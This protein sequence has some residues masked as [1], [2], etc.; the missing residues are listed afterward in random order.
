MKRLVLICLPFALTGCDKVIEKLRGSEAEAAAETMSLF[1][2]ELS[3]GEIDPFI[4]RPNQVVILDFGA[5]W[6]G[7]CRNLAPKL[8]KLAGEYPEKIALGKIDVDQA[9]A[10]AARFGVSGIPDV[11]IYVNG[12]EVDRFTGDIPESNLRARI[13]PHTAS[14]SGSTGTPEAGTP[15]PAAEG[16]TIQPLQDDWLPPGMERK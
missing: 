10:E 12:R 11:R 4:A 5:T 13:E 15:A 7:P 6:C 14:V 16:S 9:G 8:E 2:T 1:T 3:E